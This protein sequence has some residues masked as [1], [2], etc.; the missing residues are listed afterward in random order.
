M[1]HKIILFCGVAAT[2]KSYWAEKVREALISENPAF[3]DLDEVRVANW[4]KEH[5]LTDV[6][7]LLKNE[8]ARLEVKKELIIKRAKLIIFV[9]TML[10]ENDHQKPFVEMV[11]ET[12]NL[13]EK[14]SGSREMIDIRAIWFDCD[15]ETAEKRIKERG[16]N[17]LLSL[18]NVTNIKKW[19]YDKSRFEP[20]IGKYYPV[21][22]IDTSLNS[23]ISDTEKLNNIMVFLSA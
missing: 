23:G 7:H 2:G 6:E 8:I 21:L 9:A 20:P 4:G 22:K 17:L 14:I 11:R 12:E 10:T 3:V 16:I 15:K 19:E 13:L 18:S 1:N 5:V